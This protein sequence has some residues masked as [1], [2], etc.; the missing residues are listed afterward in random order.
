MAKAILSA[1]EQEVKSPV[2]LLDTLERIALEYPSVAGPN[3]CPPAPHACPKCE[4]Y[5]LLAEAADR[6][7]SRQWVAWNEVYSHPQTDLWLYWNGET[8]FPVNIMRDASGKMFASLGQWGWTRAQFL[9]E[10]GGLWSPFI[11]PEPPR[12][13]T[14]NYQEV[15]A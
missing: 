8:T 1:G 13:L 7:T 6:V 5:F 12:E 9:D 14:D 11:V 4:I 3:D 10:M 2:D 15:Q